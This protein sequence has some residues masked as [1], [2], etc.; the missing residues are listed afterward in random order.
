MLHKVDNETKEVGTLFCLTPPEVP[1]AP[2]LLGTLEV[3]LP[4]PAGC[5]ALDHLIRENLGQ[6]SDS[7]VIAMLV[8]NRWCGGEW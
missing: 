3:S 4:D 2:P 5:L 6:W 1:E 8:H 7:I